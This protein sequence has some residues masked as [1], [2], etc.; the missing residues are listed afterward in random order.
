MKFQGFCFLALQ[1]IL[2]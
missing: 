2:A 1:M